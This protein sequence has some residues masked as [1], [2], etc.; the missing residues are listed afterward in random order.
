MKKIILILSLSVTLFSCRKEELTPTNNNNQTIVVPT[1]TI[2]TTTTTVQSLM[3]QKWVITQYRV[4]TLGPILPL[5]DTLTFNTKTTYHY[6]T[7]S[8]TYSFYPTGS[9]YNLTMNYTP[10]GNL[11]GNMNDYNVISGIVMGNRFVD[12]SMGSSIT[13]EYYLWM[14]K[15]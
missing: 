9:V 14:K 15:I 4:G 12:I 11:S 6:N 5:N 10:F 1:S 2:T 3:G 13:T 8:S 7:Y